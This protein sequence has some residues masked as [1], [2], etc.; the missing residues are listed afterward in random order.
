MNIIISYR[1]LSDIANTY[2]DETNPEDH[3]DISV[4]P[5]ID[6]LL[7]TIRNIK[8]S[9][10]RLK[11]KVKI[12]ILGYKNDQLILRLKLSSFLLDLVKKILF[13]FFFQ[14]VR[15]TSG[16]KDAGKLHDYMKFSGSKIYLEI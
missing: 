9:F 1:E 10:I 12:Q 8:V 14:I 5:V 16:E 4:S 15:K 3:L 11:Q 2:L 13:K 6:G 7:V